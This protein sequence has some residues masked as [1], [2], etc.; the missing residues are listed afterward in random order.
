MLFI[1]LNEIYHFNWL[2]FCSYSARDTYY[3]DIIYVYLVSFASKGT[4]CMQW[5]HEKI[6]E[7]L[8]KSFQY[9][10][11]IYKST[12]ENYGLKHSVIQ[13]DNHHS[14]P[15]FSTRPLNCVLKCYTPSVWCIIL[16]AFVTFLLLVQIHQYFSFQFCCSHY[17]VCIIILNLDKV[18]SLS[19]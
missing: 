15:L 5:K 1:L 12:K 11:G 7:F 10:K 3:D 9:I 16:Q 17:L 19:W 4:E 13:S 18:V 8:M 6:N 2:A 14:K